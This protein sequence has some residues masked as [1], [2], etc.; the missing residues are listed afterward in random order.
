MQMARSLAP[1]GLDRTERACCEEL[2]NLGRPLHLLVEGWCVAQ[3]MLLAF[4]FPVCMPPSAHP[5]QHG[6]RIYQI[7]V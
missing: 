1:L 2:Q 3:K 6:R 5:R 4:R 7:W